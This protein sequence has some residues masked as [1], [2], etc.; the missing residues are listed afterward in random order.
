MTRNP[1]VAPN[2][3]LLAWSVAVARSRKMLHSRPVPTVLI[4]LALLAM[5]FL[6]YAIVAGLD[7]GTLTAL[8]VDLTV[9]TAV[10]LAAVV[11]LGLAAWAQVRELYK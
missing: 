3:D 4:G 10:E 7:F 9:V 5:S 11:A 6:A 8:G 1:H 2:K